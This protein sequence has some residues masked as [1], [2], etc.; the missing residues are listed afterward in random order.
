VAAQMIRP[1]AMEDHMRW[2]FVFAITTMIV[3]LPV[4]EA[5]ARPGLDQP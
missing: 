3:L 2:L 4:M 5:L 1:F